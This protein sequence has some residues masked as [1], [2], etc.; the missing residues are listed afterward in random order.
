[1]LVK[2]LNL[3][4]YPTYKCIDKEGNI[5]DYIEGKTEDEFIKY[6]MNNIVN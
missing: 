6:I 3:K 1:M 4:V 5:L 2:D